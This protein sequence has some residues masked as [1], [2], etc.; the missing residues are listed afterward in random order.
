M[1]PPPKAPTQAIQPSGQSAGQSQL[2]RADF[3][4]PE[5][6]TALLPGLSYFPSLCLTCKMGIIKVPPLWVA[7]GIT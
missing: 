5:S 6:T 2:P 3:S 7:V 4:V 1:W